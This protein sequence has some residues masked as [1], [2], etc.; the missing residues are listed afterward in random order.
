MIIWSGYGFIIFIIVFV[1]SLIAE[2]ISQSVTHDET[3]Y[4]K[5]LIPL[6]LSFI[7]SG[8]VIY[9]LK[10]YFDRKKANN[11]GTR[12]FDK[13]TIAKKGHHL[14]FIPIEYWAYIITVLGIVLIGYQ[15]MR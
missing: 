6:G 11:E 14:F 2:L 8:V 1:D 12:I 10:K 5:N 13:V 9:S 4:Q 3:Y 15:M 7:V